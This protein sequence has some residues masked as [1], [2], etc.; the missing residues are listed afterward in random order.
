LSREARS[1][2]VFA[3]P[4]GVETQQLNEDKTRKLV[5][6]Y[7]NTGQITNQYRGKLRYRPDN[8]GISSYRNRRFYISV[9]FFIKNF[10][11][12][13]IENGGKISE[14]STGSMK[15]SYSAT[16]GYYLTNS[17]GLEFEYFDYSDSISNMSPPIRGN[18]VSGDMKTRNYIFNFTTEINNSRIIPFFAVGLGLAQSDF[19]YSAASDTNENF[20]T[21]SKLVPLY[22]IVAGFEFEIS[23][24]LLFSFRYRIYNTFRSIETNDKYFFRYGPRN[25]F[26]VGFKYIL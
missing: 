4:D 21:S 6:T 22:Q 10:S 5:N 1:E 24:Q 9:Y 12:K 7:K 8:N 25:N 23:D 2:V 18:L 17:I 26:N 19:E 15:H 16:F 20:K 11:L 14:I 3:L 13:E